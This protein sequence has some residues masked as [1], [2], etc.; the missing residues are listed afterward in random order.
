MATYV[1]TGENLTITVSGQ[2][3][4]PQCKS[5]ELNY[6]NSV[7]TVR[8][9][10]GSKSYI[11]GTTGTLVVS[12]FQDVSEASSFTEALWSAAE[13]GT[14]VSFTLQVGGGSGTTFTGNVVPQ[15]PTI[16]GAADAALESSITFT[17]DGAVTMDTTP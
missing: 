15:F 3:I 17:I 11:S 2:A 10:T 12:M 5:V 13:T 14:S 8:T 6:E 4:S 7:E 9:L 1:T 16:G